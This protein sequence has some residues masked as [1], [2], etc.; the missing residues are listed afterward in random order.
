MF[1]FKKRVRKFPGIKPG[2]II[3]GID[4]SK[5]NSM[6]DLTNYLSTKKVGDTVQISI[7]DNG[8]GIPPKVL[9]KI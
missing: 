7:K 4:S 5:V 3:I 1:N 2:D 6:S 8:N 9:D